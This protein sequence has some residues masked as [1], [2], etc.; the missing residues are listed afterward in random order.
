VGVL[1]DDGMRLQLDDGD[2]H[3]LGGAGA[4]V[5]AREDGVP[6]TLLGGREILAHVGAP[7]LEI[8]LAI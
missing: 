4:N 8:A 3:P 2:H 6:G 5:N 7:F 1:L